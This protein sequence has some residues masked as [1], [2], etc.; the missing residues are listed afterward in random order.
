MS[1]FLFIFK[2]ISLSNRDISRIKASYLHIY[3]LFLISIKRGAKKK[4]IDSMSYL[5]LARKKKKY[6]LVKK[7]VVITL[8]FEEMIK[9]PVNRYMLNH[10]LKYLKHF[11]SFFFFVRKKM[12]CH[13][14]E[15]M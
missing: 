5:L 7:E 10:L 15:W 2:T 8:F 13:K 4:K 12:N 1:V 3:K 6:N 9:Q 11:H 14:I